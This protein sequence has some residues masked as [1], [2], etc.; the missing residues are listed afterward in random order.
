MSINAAKGVEIGSGFAA[1]AL[2]GEDN[3]D[4]MRMGPDGPVFLSNHAGGV[5]GGISTGQTGG[6]ARRVQADLVHPDPAPLHRRGWRRGRDPH[7]RPPR[8]LRRHQG[9][10][11]RGSD[12]G[13]RAGRCHAPASWAGGLIPSRPAAP[14]RFRPSPRSHRLRRPSVA[15][16]PHRSASGDPR[17]RA[18]PILPATARSRCRRRRPRR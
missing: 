11:G 18:R 9:G 4:E 12:D 5:L 13:L 10:P 8:P 17:V 7:H 15:R 16:S 1:A 2:S 3:A 14:A 6:G